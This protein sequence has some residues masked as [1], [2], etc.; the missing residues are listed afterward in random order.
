MFNDGFDAKTMNFLAKQSREKDAEQKASNFILTIEERV[1][2]DASNGLIS[3]Y[4]LS[5]QQGVLPRYFADSLV[6]SKV[7]TYFEARGFS[8]V[9]NCVRE[10]VFIEWKF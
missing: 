1:R 8:I 6:M 9:I 3:S 5:T 7:K 10:T 4:L 2:N